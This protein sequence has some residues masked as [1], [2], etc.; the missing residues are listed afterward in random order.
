MTRTVLGVIGGSGV[1][2]I[3][4]LENPRWQAVKTPWGEPS[5]QLLTGTFHGAPVVAASP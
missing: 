3:E 5:D 2:Q 4:G 1:Y